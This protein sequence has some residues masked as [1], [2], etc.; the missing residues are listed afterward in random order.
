MVFIRFLLYLHLINCICLFAPART[1]CAS[2]M[3]YYIWF[4]HRCANVIIIA[5]EIAYMRAYCQVTINAAYVNGVLYKQLIVY[6][7]QPRF[8]RKYG[9]CMVS[10]RFLSYL[11][12]INCICLFAPS[13]RNRCIPYDIWHMIQ[14]SMCKHQTS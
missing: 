14:M 11:H 13:P 4:K 7:K 6:W 8:H 3:T 5:I 9:K 1:I 2:F 12:W 10:I